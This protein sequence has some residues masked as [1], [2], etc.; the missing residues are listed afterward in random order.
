LADLGGSAHSFGPWDVQLIRDSQ[1]TGNGLEGDRGSHEYCVPA[2]PELPVPYYPPL[3]ESVKALGL[4]DLM[5]A[6]TGFEAVFQP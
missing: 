4:K 1:L 3:A 6:R 5:A 2:G